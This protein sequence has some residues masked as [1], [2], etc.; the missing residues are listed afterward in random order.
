[1][2]ISSSISGLATAGLSLA[3]PLEGHAKVC[4]HPRSRIGV[5]ARWTA[6]AVHASS[7]HWASPRDQVD[8]PASSLARLRTL[9]LTRLRLSILCYLAQQR[10]T[11]SSPHHL[12]HLH[13]PV[14]PLLRSA[15]TRSF[16]FPSLL[17]TSLLASAFNLNLCGHDRPADL[18]HHREAA[19][20]HDR[21]LFQ[22]FGCFRR[23]VVVVD[24]LLITSSPNLSNA[25]LSKPLSPYSLQY[26]LHLGREAW[27]LL[28][29]N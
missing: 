8:T 1:V 13:L 26:K 3:C 4:W 6:E 9:E 2:V 23:F 5:I 24:W 21:D 17:E 19:T 18:N 28:P 27:S 29:K 7:W 11:L 10:L 15:P 22:H 14:S 12:Y 20:S 25:R 16:L